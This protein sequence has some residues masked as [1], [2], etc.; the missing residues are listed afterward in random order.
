MLSLS[1]VLLVLG[2]LIGVTIIFHQYEKIKK[3]EKGYLYSTV[4]YITLEGV[5]SSKMSMLYLYPDKIT[6][7]DIQIIP[8][9]RVKHATFTMGSK[10]IDYRTPLKRRMYFL[11]I[12]F[13][14]KKGKINY[15]KCHSKKNQHSM[16]SDYMN[17]ELK[18]NNHIGYVPP[19]LYQN[20]PYEL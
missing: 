2:L 3:D 11:T 19:K 9:E 12:E 7:N 16:H 5:D 17:M 13:K 6:I 10:S 8:I 4:G 15:I 18:I 14:D 20:K 1:Y